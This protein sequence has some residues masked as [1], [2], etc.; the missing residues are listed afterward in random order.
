MKLTN[1]IR[2]EWSGSVEPQSH[3]WT[4]N[5][6]DMSADDRADVSGYRLRSWNHH[7]AAR[8]SRRERCFAG[9]TIKPAELVRSTI[10]HRLRKFCPKR[11]LSIPGWRH[12]RGSKRLFR[13]GCVLDT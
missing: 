11:L 10:L 12:R 7:R 5:V 4:D 13:A 8:D 6:A 1:G 3:T 2:R 9:V